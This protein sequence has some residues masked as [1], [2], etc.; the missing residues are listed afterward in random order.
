M[1]FRALVID[2]QKWAQKLCMLHTQL[3]F[4]HNLPPPKQKILDET[5]MVC[6]ARMMLMINN[7]LYAGGMTDS[8]NQGSVHVLS[9]V[10]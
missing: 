5:L 4:A 7:E 3:I 6:W 9:T 8:I 10:V 1:F 2:T